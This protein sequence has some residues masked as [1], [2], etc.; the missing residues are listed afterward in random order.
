MDALKLIADALNE[1]VA[2]LSSV[3]GAMLDVAAADGHRGVVEM[4]LALPPP[5]DADSS[6]YRI[7]KP[8]HC[9][10][11]NGHPGI[12]EVL[13]EEPSI[14]VNDV[15]AH[16][17]TPLDL[18][19]RFEHSNV[20]ELLLLVPGVTVRANTLLCAACSGDGDTMKMLLDF[21][22]IN[23]NGVGEHGCTALHPAVRADHRDVVSAL[24]GVPHIDVNVADHCGCTP[25]HEAVSFKRRELV[26][27][28]L[29]SPKVDVNIANNDGRTALHLAAFS[30]ESDMAKMLLR[31]PSIDFNVRDNG[32]KTPADLA[33]SYRCCQIW[34]WTRSWW[35]RPLFLRKLILKHRRCCA[36]CHSMF[37]PENQLQ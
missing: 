24:L 6:G 19:V 7:Q 13:L 22:D 10:S 21:Q 33:G 27:A 17:F 26:A 4:L 34:A 9:A 8:L 37:M 28:L 11:M 29:A 23:V 30:F 1:G 36:L 32:G 35:F 5:D 20:V 16:N 2:L 15:D 18:A 25:L 12:V 3:R 31:M 14:G